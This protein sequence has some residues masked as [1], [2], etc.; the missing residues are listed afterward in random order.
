MQRFA[1]AKDAKQQAT[2]P[3]N[4]QSHIHNQPQAACCIKKCATTKCTALQHIQRWGTRYC[5]TRYKKS[6][7][8]ASHHFLIFRYSSTAVLYTECAYTSIHAL[9]DTR[10]YCYLLL[11]VCTSVPVI[12]WYIG[13]HPWHWQ[14]HVIRAPFQQYPHYT[15][16]T[17]IHALQQ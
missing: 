7:G 16:H 3:N 12:A 13:E 6:P 1:G 8:V 2:T 4:K 11:V 5:C 17:Y 10:A 14:R 15:I 9:M